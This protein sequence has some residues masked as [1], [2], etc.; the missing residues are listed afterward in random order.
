MRAKLVSP[1]SKVSRGIRKS[2]DA[3]RAKMSLLSGGGARVL[4][5]QSNARLQEARHACA[6]SDEGTS[7]LSGSRARRLNGV[8]KD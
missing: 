8:H 3:Y 5:V 6:K 2:R 4:K 1:G 7:R